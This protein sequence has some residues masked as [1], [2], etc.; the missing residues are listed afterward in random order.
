MLLYRSSTES[1][2]KAVGM[3]EHEAETIEEK[4]AAKPE[5]SDK[6]GKVTLQTIADLLGVSRTTVSN[7][8]GKPDQLAPA[9]REKIFKTA[10]ELGYCGPNAAASALRRGHSGAVGLIFA[11]PL[12]YAVSDPAAA[13]FLQALAEV[14]DQKGTSLVIL[15]KPV[16]REAGVHAV[17][18]AFVIYSGSED[19]PR[20]TALLGRN[21][22]IVVLDEPRQPGGA[23][24]GIDDFDGA[25]SIAQHLLD[26]GHR[27]FG[28]LTFPLRDDDYFGWV[29]AERRTSATYSVTINRLNGYAEAITAAGLDWEAVPAY[30]VR[31]NLLENGI[32]G[33]T[34]LLALDPPPTAILAVSD[35]LALGVLEVARSHGKGVPGVLSVA[36][37]DDIPAAETAQIPLTTVR[38]PLRGKGTAA[39]RMVVDG[40]DLDRPP[41]LILPTELVIRASTG[42]APA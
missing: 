36:G 10:G 26:L 9:L 16:E 14:F 11:E 25:R 20:L 5:K 30:E 27:R 28:V 3:G 1:I 33:A 7:A 13:A 22:P 39:A 23:Y 15:P 4:R 40:W 32:A 2:K 24:I 29:S 21:L 34:A 37:F 41:E 6:A 35:Q 12:S 38:Q 42:P 31:S 8:Y 19:D 17:R 18:D